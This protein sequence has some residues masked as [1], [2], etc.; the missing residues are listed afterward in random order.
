[1]AICDKCLDRLMEIVGTVS[2]YTVAITGD[3]RV[4]GYHGSLN[5]VEGCKDAIERVR[6]DIAKADD[7]TPD[8]I[9]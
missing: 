3:C 5:S 1:M 4:C 8:S 2:I 7:E 6:K 9:F